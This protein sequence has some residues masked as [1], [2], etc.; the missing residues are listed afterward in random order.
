MAN[1]KERLI[2]GA[3]KRGYALDLHTT[4]ST[5][6]GYDE[7]GHARFDSTR[8]EVG[9]LLYR[10][11]YSQDGAAADEIAATAQHLLARWK[12]PIDMIVP[13]PPTSQRALQPV[14]VLAKKIAE[15]MGIDYR[16]CV[17]RV[18]DI[19]QLKNVSDLDERAKLLDG[20]HKVDATVTAGKSILLFDDL[21]RSGATMNA[22][23]AALYEEGKATAVYAL[24][25]TRTRSNA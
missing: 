7:Y 15:R 21:F 19:P 4:G 16:E 17:N 5:F 20:A 12:L 22:I 25:V 3:W 23:T 2:Q 8:S 9:E 14:P 6:L 18:K 13:V 10:L 1:Y 11:K 24:T